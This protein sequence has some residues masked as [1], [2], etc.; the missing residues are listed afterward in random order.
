MWNIPGGISSHISHVL[1]NLHLVSLDLMSTSAVI[2]R[3]WVRRNGMET[4]LSVKP[5]TILFSSPELSAASSAP[6]QLSGTWHCSPGWRTVGWEGLGAAERCLQTD[7]WTQI[8][9]SRCPLGG[10]GRTYSSGLSPRPQKGSIGTMGAVFLILAG[11]HWPP[12]F[13]TRGLWASGKERPHLL[14]VLAQVWALQK[15]PT[16]PKRWAAVSERERAD[17]KAANHSQ[18]AAAANT[19]SWRGCRE[20]ELGLEAL[21]FQ[22]RQWLPESQRADVDCALCSHQCGGIEASDRESFTLL[23]SDTAIGHSTLRG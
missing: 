20:T 2:K 7:R 10:Q 11:S 22:L 19:H 16:S 13:K 14:E 12:L 1:N 23:T 5:G 17:R 9:G 21:T 4:Q 8:A 18:L 3:E 6:Q 15:S